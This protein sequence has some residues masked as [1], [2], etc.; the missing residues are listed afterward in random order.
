MPRK[1][2]A[3]M[4]QLAPQ[5]LK[6]AVLRDCWFEPTFHKHVGK[7]CNG[8]QIHVE[9]SGTTTMTASGRGACRRWP[10]RRSAGL[11]P[12][13]PCG[14]ILPYEYAARSTSWPST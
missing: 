1:V 8:V 9:D 3:E 10:S 2:I 12:D 6:V 13:Y 11:Y 14:G 4:Y 7:L 5:W